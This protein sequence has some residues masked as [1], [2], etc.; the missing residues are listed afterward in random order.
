MSKKKTIVWYCPNQTHYQQYLFNKIVESQYFNFKVVYFNKKLRKYPWKQ[1]FKANT[2]EKFLNKQLFKIDFNHIFHKKSHDP[3]YIIAGWSEPTMILMLTYLAIRRI[4]YLIN[5]DTPRNREIVGA[6][7][8][9]RKYWL[10]FILS[11]SQSI[12]VTGQIG[13]DL[14][15]RWKVKGLEVYNFPFTTNCDFFKP[16]NLYS[17]NK[18]YTIF[19]SG[20][21]DIS[22]KGY[23]VAFYALHQII[24]K[25]PQLNILYKIAGV[26]PDEEKL[27]GLAKELNITD[28]IEFLGWKEIDELPD[29]YNSAN[30]FLHPSNRDP[31]PNAILEAMASG[32][33]VCASDKAGSGKE[34]IINRQNGYLYKSGDIKDLVNVL[35]E[36]LSLPFEKI[37]SIRNDSR[38]TAL[39]WDFRYNINLLNKII[40]Y[41]PCV[42]D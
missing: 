27:I 1:D 4:P 15:N 30:L 13:V 25:F 12:L 20:R 34:R 16:N 11:R 28:H 38:Q 3:T 14:I 21:L 18:R 22:H 17:D 40:N 6:K 10:D 19:S 5:T 2:E 42:K 32:C 31:F 26:G 8:K 24:K 37:H 7:E 35:S 33:L 23:D 36:I 9:L 41:R 39:K 29:L